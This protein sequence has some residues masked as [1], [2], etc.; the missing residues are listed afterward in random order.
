MTLQSPKSRRIALPVQLSTRIA[1]G[2]FV[3]TAGGAVMLSAESSKE[4]IN[5]SSPI[6]LATFTVI[7]AFLGL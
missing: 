4:E 7:L 1:T 6:S 2:V 5:F 3:A